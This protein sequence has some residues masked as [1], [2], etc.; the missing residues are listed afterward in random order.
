MEA[1][2]PGNASKGTLQLENT[3]KRDTLVAIEKKYQK[4]WQTDHIFET[5]APSIQSVP[6]HS[7]SPKELRSKHPKYFGTMAYP[8]MNG[9]LH[10]GH[11]FTMSKVE[12]AVGWARMQ[13]KRVLFPQGFHCTGMPIK[14]CADKLVREMAM[15]GQEFERCPA[16]QEP[17]A[18][19]PPAGDGRGERKA[20]Q[21]SVQVLPREDVTKF[22]AKKGK[23]AAKKVALDYQFQIMMAIGIPRQ[24]IHH[25]SNPQHWLDYFPPLCKRDMNAFGAR[26]D[27]R[28][29]FVTTDANPYYDAFVRWQMNRLRE[30]K[31]IKFGLRYTIYS[32]KDGQPCMDHDRSEGEGV[33]PQEYTAIK[34]RVKQWSPQA[35]DALSSSVPA[36]VNAYLVAAT[37]RPETMYGQTCCFVGPSITYGIFRMKG[38]EYFL[39]TDRAAKN[40][41]YQ[42][43][44]SQN[45]VVEKVAEIKGEDVVGTIVMAPLSKYAQGVRVLPMDTVLAT[46][47][48]GVVTCVPSDSPDDFATTTELA[49]KPEFYRIQKEWV[50]NEP[51]PVIN[52]PTYGDLSAPFLVKLLKINSPKDTK[53]LA[54]AKDLAYKEGFYQGTMVAGEYKGEKV[55]IAKPKVKSDLIKKNE[56][57][58]YAEPENPVKS[59]SGDPC[60]VAL[61][62]QWYLDY[63]ETNWR[64]DALY[65]LDNKLNTYNSETRNGFEGVLN[66]L[67]QWACARTYGLGSKLPWDPHFLVESLSDSTIYMAYYTVAHFLHADIFGK[68]PGILGIR[69]DQMTDEIWDFVFARRELEEDLI[70]KSGISKSSLESMRREFEYWY[71]LDIRVSGKDLIPNHLTFFIYIHLALFSP[72]YWPRSIRA[73][74]HLMLNGEKMSKSTGNFLTLDEIIRKFG[75]DSAR[76]AFADAGDT[77]EDANF[78]ET[79]ANSVILRFYNLKEWCADTLSSENKVKLRS[80]SHETLW[81]RLFHND[82]NILADQARFAYEATNYKTALKAALYDLQSARDFYRNNSAAAGVGMHE[83]LVLKYIEFQALLMTPIAPHFAEYL[84]L[85]VL[86][87]DRS[88]HWAD[89][90]HY[91][92]EVP[93][94]TD[95]KSYIT[96]TTS[97]ITSV[98]ANQLKKLAKGKTGAFDPK[99][100]R[101]LIIFVAEDW[102]QWQTKYVN[103]LDE[104]VDSLNHVSISDKELSTRAA[105]LSSKSGDKSEAKKAMPFLQGLKRRIATGEPKPEVL[106]RKLKFDEKLVLKEIEK[107]LLKLTGCE[108]LEVVS[109]GSTGSEEKLPLIADSAVPG[110]PTILFENIVL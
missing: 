9:T 3:E 31:K 15:F 101:K 87:K 43:I 33:G 13:G 98:Q 109:K 75:A 78:E 19:A 108:K 8:Y 74:G 1:L 62:D 95:I 99:A 107:D 61:M 40:M 110:A 96:T 26:V 102:P 100:P 37:L 52:T 92:P 60:V 97:S 30:L 51:V 91:A 12:F 72:E 22:S 11:S 73:N 104:A 68:N 34:L 24:D 71:P 53:Q 77:V 41:A 29:S 103:L 27:W 20:E 21:A 39:M 66:W 49:K 5:D 48:T 18:S 28:R 42:G 88:I 106:N 10:A 25:F 45:G 35:A 81:D 85:E 16:M 38:N 105:A 4:Q 69:P 50:E 82:L 79:V 90:P 84:W 6:Y 83:E 94:L 67:N 58:A 70:S 93:K 63:G 7:I 76:I 80:D 57:F 23:A 32:E 46:K 56:A 54:E 86:R 47:G 14:A 89:Y 64:K 2:D 44:F 65:F 17:E 55:E 36:S 59:R